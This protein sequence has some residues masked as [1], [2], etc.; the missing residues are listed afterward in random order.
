MFTEAPVYL[1]TAAS[2]NIG[3]RLVPLLL[4][5]LPKPTLVL[6]TRDPQRLRS[7][8]D[9]QEHESR[10]HVID[11]DL[12]DPQFIESIIKRHHVSAVFICLTG[13]DELVVTLNL[14]D[15]IKRAETVKHVV[16][17]SAAGRFDFEAI[18]GGELRNNAAGHILVKPILEAKLQYGL[19][20]AQGE[21]GGFTWTIIGPTLFFDNDMRSKQSMLKKG[22]FDEPL[23]RKGVS[24][25][26]PGDIAL[27][28]ANALQDNGKVWGG[29]KIM[30]GS[31]ERYTNADVAR[32]WSEALGTNI[33][34]AASDEAGLASFEQ[35][36][37]GRVGF[38]WARDMR[39]MYE[40]FDA[41][42]FGMDEA[43]YQ[44]QVALLGKTPESYGRFVRKM[45]EEWKA[46]VGE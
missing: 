36:W 2:G 21:P 39:L 1:L 13:L 25:V 17:V 18:K 41:Q 19:P 6:P 45:A 11:G 46:E 23:G 14:F 44:D 16:Y 42:G 40:F 7:Q 28:V 12:Q 24:R 9:F 8:V 35:D 30:I 43:E 27:A 4:S 37:R 38:I 3:K 5:Q 15:A 26:D 33:S 31:L 29:K 34:H 22:F 20:R 32:L 10:V